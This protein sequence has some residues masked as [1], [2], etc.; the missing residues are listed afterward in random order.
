MY[1]HC[2]NMSHN[3]HHLSMTVLTNLVFIIL[4]KFAY[5]NTINLHGNLKSLVGVPGLLSGHYDQKA[6]AMK[7][8]VDCKT[9]DCK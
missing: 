2:A 1:A 3:Y 8:D 5:R 6:K 7:S 9:H 4:Y